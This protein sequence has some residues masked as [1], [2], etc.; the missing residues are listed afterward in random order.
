[1]RKA[2]RGWVWGGS[3]QKKGAAKMER[4]RKN[5]GLFVKDEMLIRLKTGL[6]GQNQHS[7]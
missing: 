7:R 3:D 5:G 1:M 4:G 6:R 2:E